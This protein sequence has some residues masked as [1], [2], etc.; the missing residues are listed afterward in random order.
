MQLNGTTTYN[1]IPCNSSKNLK[2]KTIFKIVLLLIV[3]ANYSCKAQ[4]LVQTPDDINKLKTNEQQFLTKPLKNLL[5][6][7]KPEIKTAFGTA[8]SPS[9]F[10]FKFLSPSEINQKVTGRKQV[11]FYVYV[12]ENF[13]WNPEKRTKENEFR[14]TSADTER[15]GNLTVIRIKVIERLEN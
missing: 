3:F 2:M 12:K 13:E 6:E 7:I 4:Q 14:W 1:S 9:F 11:S 8:G 15:Y 5:Q 10:T